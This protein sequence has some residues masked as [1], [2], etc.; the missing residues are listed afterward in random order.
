MH[1]FIKT[2]LT[3]ICIAT[4]AAMTPVMA[5]DTNTDW[6]VQVR[7]VDDTY[8]YE[9]NFGTSLSL[10]SHLSPDVEFYHDLGGMILGYEALAK[11]NS[12]MDSTKNRGR[13]VLVPD[14]LR[15]FPMRNGSDI[16]GAIIMG[17]HDFF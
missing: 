10:N 11:V 15:I 6:E 7:K 4:I 3:S 12:G 8:W 1:N 16:Y 17:E 9:F 5:K 2:F 13:R 14:T